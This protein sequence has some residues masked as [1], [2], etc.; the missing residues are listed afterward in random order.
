MKCGGFTNDKQPD[1]TSSEILTQIK[2][3]CE[4]E[5]NAKFTTWD[6]VSY[7]TQVVAGTNYLFK[8]NIGDGKHISVKVF[9]PLP[10]NGTELELL[11]CTAI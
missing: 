4:T 1:E 5:M 10:C 11:S 3:K 8:V 9:Q 2:P 6:C 7:T